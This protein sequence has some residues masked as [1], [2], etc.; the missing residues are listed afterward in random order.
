[1]RAYREPVLAAHPNIARLISAFLALG[2]VVALLGAYGLVAA[3]LGGLAW[4]A[5]PER[6]PQV[7]AVRAAA[8]RSRPR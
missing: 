1:M 3:I 7:R 4:F 5:L 6:R 8:P 2:A